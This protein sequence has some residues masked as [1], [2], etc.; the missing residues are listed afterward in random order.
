MTATNA[1]QI[2]VLRR[3]TGER[4]AIGDQIWVWYEGTLVDGTPF[5]ANY[6]FS[7]F[8]P[9]PNRTEFSFT[10][11]VGQVIKGWDQALQNRQ[12]GEVLELTIP[13]ELAYGSSGTGSLIPPNATLRFKV[14]I[15]AKRSPGSSVISGLTL[16]NL[17][18]D[19]SRFQQQLG[20]IQAYKVGLDLGDSLTGGA[21]RDLLLGLD[22]N[23]SLKGGNEAD[24]LVAGNGNDQ[25]EG[26]VGDDVLDGGAGSD[27]AV[28]GAANNTVRLSVTGPQ[29]T[30]EGR[31]TLIAIENVSA[32]GGN[33]AITGN[34]LS[35]TLN[36]G[37]GRDILDGGDGRDQLIGGADADTFLYTLPS[38]SRAGSGFRDTISD[39]NGASGDK[40]NLS[41]LDASSTAIGNQAFT[42]I[43]AQLFSGTAGEVRFAAGLLQLNTDAD[44]LANME[45]ELSNVSIFAKEYFI[46]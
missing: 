40:I 6:K 30:G 43:G 33:D 13:S 39:F 25:L 3:S 2:S 10:L 1:L 28:Y 27:T 35:N 31:D 15:V 12:I 8:N 22:G 4:L 14:E 24:L 18:I 29:Q 34:A 45:I 41:A 16:A 19:A 23:D 36:G 42:Y 44:R 46:A 9:V 37:I 7:S 5:D 38:Q 21:L 32:G 20:L 17:G 26:G 11:G